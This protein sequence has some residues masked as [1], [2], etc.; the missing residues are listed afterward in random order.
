MG[1][2]G[3][4]KEAAENAVRGRKTMPQGLK[5][6]CE[7]ILVFLRVD[8][9]KEVHVAIQ[10]LQSGPSISTAAECER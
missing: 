4:T 8:E 5:R 10:A 1:L 3:P 7:N 9:A 2:N 6:V